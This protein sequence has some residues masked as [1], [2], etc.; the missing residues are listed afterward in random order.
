LTEI[1]RKGIALGVAE[2]VGVA[3]AAGVG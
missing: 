3:E 1:K 2:A